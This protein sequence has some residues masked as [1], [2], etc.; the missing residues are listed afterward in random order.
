MDW[1]IHTTVLTRGK[2]GASVYRQ[3]RYIHVPVIDVRVV[4]TVGA[5]DSFSAAFLYGYFMTGDLEQGARLAA[6]VSSFVT[7]RNGAVPPYS[8][9][10]KTVLAKI[11]G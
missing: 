4:D 8:K 7:S 3:G 2:D 1:S 5:G 9:E 11:S 10:I 6:E